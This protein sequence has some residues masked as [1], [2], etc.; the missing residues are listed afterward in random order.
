MSILFREPNTKTSRDV[1]TDVPNLFV[2][3]EQVE[4]SCLKSEF[5][6]SKEGIRLSY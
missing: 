2:P 3:W 5:R 4:Q 1:R 6:F